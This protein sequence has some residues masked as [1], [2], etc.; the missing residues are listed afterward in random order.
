MGKLSGRIPP[1]LRFEL[2]YEKMPSGCWEWRRARTE[3]GPNG[4]GLIM[5]DRKRMTAHRYA[6]ILAHG[7]TI[8]QGWQVCH[9]CDNPCCVNPEHLFL[10]T[11]QD[12]QNDRLAKNRLW[13]ARE[14]VRRAWRR[15]P[16]RLPAES[17][18]DPSAA[19]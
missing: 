17:A 11:P 1:E 8:P 18:N 6:Y 2:S 3:K 13:P 4:Y 19:R 16:S 9:H 7:G 14:P 15:K 10:G 5:V 12:N